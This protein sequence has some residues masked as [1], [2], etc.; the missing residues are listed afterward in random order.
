M[1]QFGYELAACGQSQV[2]CKKASIQCLSTCGGV[3][4]SQYKH[5]FSTIVSLT[6][7]SQFVLGDAF[8][9]A[10]AANCTVKN[11]KFMVP[12]FEGG[13]SFKTFAARTRVRSKQPHFRT[14]ARAHA[15][16]RLPLGG[17]PCRR[18]DGHR[19]CLLQRERAQLRRRAGHARALAR[20]RLCQRP[21]CARQ[22][23]R[24][25]IAAARAGPAP[26]HFRLRAPPAVATAAARDA[27]AVLPGT[28]GHSN[29]RAARPGPT[30]APPAPA[31]DA[32]Q[33]IPLPRLADYGLDM[34]TDAVK[35]AE[36]EE[37]SS[38]LFARR[39][40]GALETRPR[41]RAFCA[42]ARFALLLADEKRRA[43]AC[44]ARI[45]Y[46]YPPPPPVRLESA[47]T[48]ATSLRRQRERLGDLEAYPEPRKTDEAQWAQD[49][50]KALKGTNALIDG[51]GENN[52]VL[53]SLL[54]GVKE[55]LLRAELGA[56]ADATAVNAGNAAAG[57]DAPDL[58]Q[59]AVGTT[60]TTSYGYGRRLMQRLEYNTRMTDALITHEVMQFYGKGGIPG[61]TA[62]SVM[63]QKSN[64]NHQ[65]G[66]GKSTQAPSTSRAV[67]GALRGHQAGRQREPHR[68]VQRLR[69]QARDA[70]LVRR[71][72]GL[73]LPAA[74]QRRVQARGLWRRALHAPDRVGA[75]VLRERARARQ[76]VSAPKP[77]HAL[78]PRP[79]T[80]AHRLR[81]Q[82]RSA[83]A[84][85]RRSTTRACSHT[86]TRPPPR[87]RCRTRGTRRRAR[88]GCRC[89]APS[90]S[91]C[92]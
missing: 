72:D 89:R 64:P 33:C 80:N 41:P 63:L 5:D 85:P 48:G 34:N 1:H 39:V 20:A 4:G 25:A 31:Q 87:T 37:R 55:E 36:S 12:T 19:R 16:T 10:A 70:L 40:L 86:P 50:S 79:C 29:P 67:R 11:Y 59:S 56:V 13:D 62:G 61:I 27:A 65:P 83:S 21:V 24:A 42:D 46:P 28:R 66:R 30:R 8:D 77:A 84:C 58:A 18:H 7:L 23:A 14:N 71:P 49:S 35:G 38:C 68:R 53:K 90:S 60:S 52:P 47:S 54:G 82:I 51:L 76:C 43:S 92:P 3:D 81:T 22:D 45:A 15:R 75:P 78:T 91:P 2:L 44:F 9:D 88:A 6:E 73:V 57:A 69:L 32:E 17:T 74:A 26:A